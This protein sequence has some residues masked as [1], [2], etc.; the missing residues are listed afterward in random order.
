MA[1]PY[2]GSEWPL[3]DQVF[4]LGFVNAELLHATPTATWDIT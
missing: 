4:R 2:L 3:M 1:P